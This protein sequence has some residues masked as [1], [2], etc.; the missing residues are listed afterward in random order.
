ML[1]IVGL[2]LSESNEVEVK[3][4]FIWLENIWL[5]SIYHNNHK[6]KRKKNK[7]RKKKIY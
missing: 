6:Q 2:E 3:N 5:Y 1:Y 4:R 7:K